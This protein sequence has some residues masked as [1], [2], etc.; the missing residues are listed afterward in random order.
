M[1]FIENIVKY[2]TDKICIICNI[3]QIFFSTVFVIL[4]V[5]FCS[6][7]IQVIQVCFFCCIK[8]IGIFTYPNFITKMLFYNYLLIPKSKKV[9]AYTI[10]GGTPRQCSSRINFVEPL[11]RLLQHYAFFQR[12][13]GESNS[14]YA[15][16]AG[17]FS[18]LLPMPTRCYLP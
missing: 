5:F 17:Q 6:K 12:K 13:M 9:L 7:V 1:F 11:L 3:P 8:A 18:R 14:R 10:L 4:K 2:Q 15:H 16:H